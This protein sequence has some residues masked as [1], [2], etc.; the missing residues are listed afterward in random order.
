MMRLDLVGLYVLIVGAFEW[1]YSFRC[2]LVSFIFTYLAVITLSLCFV[3]LR[4]EF[5][6]SFDCG[7]LLFV[8]G[9]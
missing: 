9:L 6:F 1:N 2:C 7:G 8:F 3:I 4:C 5:V